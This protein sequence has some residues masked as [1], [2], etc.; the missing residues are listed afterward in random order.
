VGKL[1]FMN[2]AFSKI[3]R[4]RIWRPVRLRGPQHFG[5]KLSW[6]LMA[7]MDRSTNPHVLLTD[8]TLFKEIWIKKE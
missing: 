5:P 3:D 1:D 8:L 6:K 7:F 4:Q 2:K